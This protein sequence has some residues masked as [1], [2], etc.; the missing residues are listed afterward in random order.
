METTAS[1]A[2][3]PDRR[4]F[5]LPPDIAYL[6]AAAYG[7]L[8]LATAE[9]GRRALAARAT[10]WRLGPMAAS[11]D[12][13]RARS[14]AAILINARPQDFALVTS[15]SHAVAIAAAVLPVM[16]GT[17]VLRLA[18]E[19]PSNVLSWLTLINKGCVEQIV[20]EPADGDWTSA[21]L[22]AI[23]REGAL[24]LAVATFSRYHWRDGGMLDVDVIARAVRRAG[25][26]LFI[27]ATH[28]VGIDPVDISQL[29]PDFLCFPLFKWLMGPYGMAFVYV[30]PMWQ[31]GQP[32]DRSATNC[33]LTA[34]FA[35]GGYADGA[36]RYDRGGRDDPVSAAIAAS[37]LSQIQSWGIANVAEHVRALGDGL[38]LVAKRAGAVVRDAAFR[39][40]HI[41]GLEFE[42]AAVATDIV[43]RLA[44]QGVIVSARTD[45]VRVSPHVYNDMS[46]VERFG[47]ALST[48]IDE[49]N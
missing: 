20:A 40:P 9:A 39:A 25:G 6:N 31:T 37:A 11:A 38:A 33:K 49:T 46:D 21:V 16:P 36:R 19:H 43:E 47:R 12:V 8:S 44:A 35:W 41:I 42:S 3:L 5:D 15:V 34:D 23:E 30:D 17:R 27:D 7:P 2:A 22:E 18:G 26:V 32:T 45:T 13:E 48:A 10:P 24:P 28:M 14:A 4:A 29:Q 1:K